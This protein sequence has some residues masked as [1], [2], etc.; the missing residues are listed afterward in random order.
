MDLKEVEKGNK[1][2]LHLVDLATSYTAAVIID[3]KEREIVVDRIFKIC[4]AYF[5]AP[6]KFHSNCGGEFANHVFHEMN[7]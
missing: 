3:R 1:W 7:E 6:K 5:G 4:L 2:I